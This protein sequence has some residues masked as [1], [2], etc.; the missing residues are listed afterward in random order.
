MMTLDEW[1]LTMTGSS[2]LNRKAIASLV[3]LTCRKI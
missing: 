2:S 3:L 1:W